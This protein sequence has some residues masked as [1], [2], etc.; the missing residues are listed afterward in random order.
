MIVYKIRDKVSGLFDAGGS[1]LRLNKHGKVWPTAG[2]ARAHL[3]LL[4]EKDYRSRTSKY[5]PE[6]KNLEVVE[7]ELVEFAKHDIEVFHPAKY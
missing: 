3:T 2:T 4:Q 7:F 5:R 6:A 1:R